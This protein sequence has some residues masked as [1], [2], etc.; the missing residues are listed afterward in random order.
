MILRI[1]VNDNDFTEYLEQFANDPTITHF[2]CTTKLPEYSDWQTIKKM[3]RFRELFYSTEKYIPELI[4][5]LVE[6]VKLRWELW[7]RHELQLEEWQDDDTREYLIKN[8]RV[9][10]QKS[11]TPKWENGEV[12]YI[13][14]GYYKRWWTF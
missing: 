2:F 6:G 3:D 14:L 5:E 1:T 7:V 13:C 9:E 11:L 12:V 10:F 4:D 8:F